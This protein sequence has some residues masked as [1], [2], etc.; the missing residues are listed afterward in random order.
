MARKA[1]FTSDENLL[2]FDCVRSTLATAADDVTAHRS[3]ESL[4][5]KGWTF[6]SYH[7]KIL[8]CTELCQFATGISK[9]VGGS[10]S[11]DDHIDVSDHNLRLPAMI[12]GNDILSLQYNIPHRSSESSDATKLNTTELP[13]DG[14]EKSGGSIFI[15]IDA[16]DALSCWAAQHMAVNEI[17][18]PLHIVQVPCAKAWS[19]HVQVPLDDLEKE[20]GSA[21]AHEVK[22][23]MVNKRRNVWDWTFTS[24][25]CCTISSRLTATA[26][27]SGHT[28]TSIATATATADSRSSALISASHYSKSDGASEI[29]SSR[30]LSHGSI[31]P[32]RNFQPTSSSNMSVEGSR[33]WVKTDA[34]GIDYNLLRQQNVPILFYDEIVLYQDD[35]EDCGDVIFDAKIRV[36]PSCWYILS[37]FFVR[38]DGSI[39]R[40]RDVR[41]FHRFG[42]NKINMEVS[43]KEQDLSV[44]RIIGALGG[45][46]G[47]ELSVSIL[48]NPA[49]CSEKIPEINSAEG[50]HKYYS[51]TLL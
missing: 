37:R 32:T 44:D 41:M 30:S 27:S 18:T 35:L 15:A 45:G 8:N 21:T 3:P 22:V 1:V 12:F 33:E 28:D 43:W 29:I 2:Y 16:A 9:I 25:Y 31:C 23:D 36:M 46:G 39:V 5:Y 6:Y 50:I 48:Q 10:I 14:A 38:V 34:S 19:E 17:I 40:I 4:E 47:V 13:K 42:D 51:L 11:C 7:D 26:A 24:D 49:A 20:K